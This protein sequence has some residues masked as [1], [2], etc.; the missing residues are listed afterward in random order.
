ML[1]ASNC[2]VSHYVHPQTVLMPAAPLLNVSRGWST[3][4]C[5][6][7]IKCRLFWHV[8][9][10]RHFFIKVELKVELKV[11]SGLICTDFLKHR[12]F[13]TRGS[14][15]EQ[16]KSVG[17][18]FLSV[19]IKEEGES[20]SGYSK[21]MSEEFIE[22]EMALF[23]KQCKEVDIIITTAMIP[24][25]PAPKLLRKDSV[26]AMKVWMC[27]HVREWGQAGA[28]PAAEG[29]GRTAWLR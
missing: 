28:N 8:Y 6:P 25:K 9:F 16:A 18:E 13:D 26:A 19:D 4:I 14:V 17:A 24:G 2:L 10:H 12:L 1:A 27:G 7:T 20:S 21:E 3:S 22:A 11:E 15:A 23:A 29:V 5:R